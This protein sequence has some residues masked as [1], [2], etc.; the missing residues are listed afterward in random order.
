MINDAPSFTFVDIEGNSLHFDGFRH[1]FP[2]AADYHDANWL[3]CKITMNARITVSVNGFLLTEELV[4]LA[5]TMTDIIA[6]APSENTVEFEP[7]EPYVNLV[8]SRDEQ[9]LNVLARLDLC[10]ALGPIV[11]FLFVCR[12]AE[13]ENTLRSVEQAARAFPVRGT[14]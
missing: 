1:Q 14:G 9:H 4:T 7:L 3:H 10:P 11:E 12:S 13:F 2:T 5:K 8:F 6:A